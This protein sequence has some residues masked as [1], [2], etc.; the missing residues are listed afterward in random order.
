MNLVHKSERYVIASQR[1]GYSCPKCAG[2]LTPSGAV[3]F[4]DGSDPALGHTSEPP[5]GRSVS[6]AVDPSHYCL[7]LDHSHW[8]A[9]RTASGKS[10]APHKTRVS[11]QLGPQLWNS[12]DSLSIALYQ[13]HTIHR[14]PGI[15]TWL[16]EENFALHFPP[17]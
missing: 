2:N 7:L 5:D 11:D 6:E 8:H 15:R 13:S 9:L 14:R 10:S 1:R 16:R 17:R 12:L 3:L 4:G